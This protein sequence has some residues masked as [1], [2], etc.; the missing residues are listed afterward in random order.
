M[1]L[2]RDDARALSDKIVALSK[3]DSCIVT[4]D[5]FD[6]RHIR[7]AQNMATTNGAPGSIEIAV[8]SHFGKR[9]G[10]ATGTELNDDALATLVAASEKTAQLAPENP[11]FMPPL[12]AQNYAADTA[13]AVAT[14][15]ATS[16]QLT[17]A[18][19]PVLKQAQAKNLQASGYLEIGT[20]F[21]SFA[22]S[23]GLFAYDP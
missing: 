17:A 8:E 11:E 13:F 15:D 14:R 22:T 5:G 9:A 12:G 19:A 16:D 4:I 10:S 20:A 3:A 21:S 18:I 23:K 7:F 1:I 2:S 6:S